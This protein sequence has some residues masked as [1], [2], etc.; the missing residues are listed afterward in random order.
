MDQ[1]I[2]RLEITGPI[3]PHQEKSAHWGPVWYNH[4]I[5]CALLERVEVEY[6]DGSSYV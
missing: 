2:A 1:N 6:T 5:T 3:S 4:S